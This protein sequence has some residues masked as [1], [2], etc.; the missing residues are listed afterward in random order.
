M[1]SMFSFL[2]Q[3][4]FATSG[5]VAATPPPPPSETPPTG[6]IHPE[7]GMFPDAARY[8]AWYRRT[9]P[10]AA[11]APVV[12]VLLY[13]K[14]VVTRQPYL[15]D[16]VTA[17]EAGGLLPLPIFINGVEAHVIVRDA[18]TSAHE[19]ALVAAHGR[20][21]AS[22]TLARDAVAVDAIVNTVG[23][24]LVGGPA[25]TM[26]GGRQA[27][28]AR[29][30]L[31]TKNVPYLVAAPLLIQV[32]WLSLGKGGSDAGFAKRGGGWWSGE[33]K[34]LACGRRRIEECWS[35]CL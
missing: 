9:H 33:R 28:V 4:C 7:G 18:L 2:A 27:E 15:W 26:E 29:S 17:L 30:I 16:L 19:A 21:A 20:G 22:P 32:D 6:C 13:R 10:G 31:A 11:A 23:F 1:V 35:V 5:G 34:G 24:P 3:A 8:M 14:H 25:G 12:A